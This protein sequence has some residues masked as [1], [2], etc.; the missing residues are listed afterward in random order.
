MKNSMKPYIH[1]KNEII[2]PEVR[3]LL[4][5]KHE[6]Y[7]EIVIN[8]NESYVKSYIYIYV[9]KKNIFLIITVEVPQIAK[10]QYYYSSSGKWQPIYIF[11]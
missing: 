2:V 3:F 5:I 6:Y 4:R 8:A 10:K 1:C 7:N 11:V 9:N